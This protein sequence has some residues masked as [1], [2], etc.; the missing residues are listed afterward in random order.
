MIELIQAVDLLHARIWWAAHYGALGVVE[1]I[2]LMIDVLVK[3]LV[4]GHMG[5]K[6]RSLGIFRGPLDQS[7]DDHDEDEDSCETTEDDNHGNHSVK[8]LSLIVF[9]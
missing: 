6:A 7:N 4:K 1:D 3:V 2:R 9:A 8:L 5:L